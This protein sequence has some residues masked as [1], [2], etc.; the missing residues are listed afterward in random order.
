VR[1][2]FSKHVDHVLAQHRRTMS[3]AAMRLSDGESVVRNPRV[4]VYTA[5]IVKVAILLAAEQQDRRRGHGLTSAQRA[6][7][8]P[9][10][11]ASDNDAATAL[12]REAGKARALF[13]LFRELGMRDTR[14]A[15][16]LFEPWDGIMTTT[17]D[18]L[19]LLQS[20]AAG[21]R[22]VTNGDRRY[23]LA[24]M[25]HVEPDQ[26]WGVTTGTKPAWSVAVKNGWVPVGANDWTV[27]SIGIVRPPHGHAYALAIT[28][29]GS[30]SEAAGIAKVNAIA[31]SV[32]R[33]WGR[34]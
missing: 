32:A 7:A 24:L 19:R 2:P 6:T 29:T 18:Q 10:I 1:A 30:H 31:R 11:E 23:A 5:S 22:R 8:R 17:T 28:T 20:L 4:S 21:E 15:P 33:R 13:A 16:T 27:N 14:R 25:R 34:E 9:M 12:W 26:D 3:A